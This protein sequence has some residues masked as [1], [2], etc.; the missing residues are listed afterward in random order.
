MSV[1]HDIVHDRRYKFSLIFC[2][3]LGNNKKND[4]SCHRSRKISKIYVLRQPLE[5]LFR[6]EG[7]AGVAVAGVTY[8]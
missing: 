3:N 2:N 6:D 1:N 8:R 5:I 7:D 4:S